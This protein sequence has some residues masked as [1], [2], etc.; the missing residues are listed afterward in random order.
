MIEFLSP[1]WLLAAAA[2]AVPLFLHLLRR[3]IGTRVEFPA[4]R[5]LARAEREHSRKLRLRNLLLMLLRIAAV[6]AIAAAAARPVIR[7]GGGGHAPTALAIVLDNSLSTSAIAG[8]RPVLDELRAQAR[9]VVERASAEDRVWLV[10]A[11]ATIHGGTRSAVLGAIDRTEPLAGAGD[12][13]VAV[14]T[15]AALAGSAGLREHE[16]AVLTDGQATSW[17][18]PVSLGGARVMVY[19]PTGSPP[20]NHAVIAALASPLRWTPRGAV[21]ARAL[22]ADSA[23]YRIALEGRTLARGTVARDEEIVVR[24]APPERGWTAGAVELE[25]D[26]LRGD[27]TRYFAV[28]IGPPPAVRILPG[29]G[30][31]VASAV[32]AL[33]EAERAARGT[34]ITVASADEATALPA[35][36]IAPADPV[37]LGAANRALERLGLPWRLGTPRRGESVVRSTDPSHPLEGVTA[38]LRYPLTGG[39]VEGAGVLATASGE[40]WIVSGPRYVLIA[41]PLTPEATTFPVRAAFVPWLADLLS[42]RL[43][44]DAGPAVEARPG[45]AVARPEGIDGLE[46]ANGQRVNLTGDSL[47][48]PEH[49]GVYFFLRNGARAGALV[50][51]PEPAESDLRRL[52]L[53]ALATRFRGR[54]VDAVDDGARLAAGVFAS[55]PQRPAA[56]P[57]L[58]IT[59]GLLI[60]ESIL[61]RGGPPGRA[62]GSAR[63]GPRRAA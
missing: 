6:L 45:A 38:S 60:A 57:L 34:E 9:H 31:F 55:A 12:L 63:A 56:F 59:L 5:Y 1:L 41:S 14:G 53:S 51:N 16:I 26:E 17:V 48:A 20:P 7:I 24:A 11:D 3:R 35:L 4:V 54:S 50:V 32:D 25:P 37:R 36:L 58:V 49:P 42:Q 8:G 28:W 13:R 29:A 15:A 21:Q 52:D 61:A 18:E 44:P 47:A 19:R 2:A 33:V 10:T 23:I 46:L 43:G 39:A 62:A 30:S 27:D 40:P 22:T